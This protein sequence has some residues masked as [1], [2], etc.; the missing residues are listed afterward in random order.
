MFETNSCATLIAREIAHLYAFLSSEAGQLCFA[1]IATWRAIIYYCRRSRYPEASDLASA[2]I[3]AA[4]FA[5]LIAAQEAQLS[6]RVKQVLSCKRPKIQEAS[7][8]Q[9]RPDGSPS[10]ALKRPSPCHFA[11]TD[12]AK[13]CG[14][15]FQNNPV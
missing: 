1:V 12:K 6:G 9:K 15:A 11:A 10:A 14:D 13:V 4:I 3:I 7:L 8:Y 2:M 5:V